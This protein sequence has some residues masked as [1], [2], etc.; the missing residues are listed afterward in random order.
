MDGNVSTLPLLPVSVNA[1]VEIL[2]LS[3]SLL[4]ELIFNVP[5]KVMF[6]VTLNI[7]P[8]VVFPASETE[9]RTI[10]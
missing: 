1:I 5:V 2:P 6:P 8:N 4:I 7:L 9:N 3:E 10:T